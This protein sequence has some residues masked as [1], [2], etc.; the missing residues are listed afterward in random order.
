[1]VLIIKGLINPTVAQLQILSKT[2]NPFSLHM[3]LN[4][5]IQKKRVKTQTKE[6]VNEKFS[7]GI[8]FGNRA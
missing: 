8:S 2:L 7:F 1:M 4:K 5:R 3:Q 6:T